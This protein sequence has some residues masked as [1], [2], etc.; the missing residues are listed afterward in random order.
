MLTFDDKRIRV[1]VGHYGSGKTEFSVNYALKLAEQGNKTA[2]ADLDIANP[3]FRSRERQGLLEEQGVRVYSNIFGYDITADLPAITAAIR[4][5]L[6]DPLC[7]I[8]IDA[9]GDH[10]GA[11]ILIQFDR[12]FDQA[13]SDFFCVVN[14]RRPETST[15]A[16]AMNHIFKIEKETG[17]RIT[18]LINN[19]H[20]LKETEAEDVIRGYHLC[21]ELSSRL[22][23]PF[24]YN[25]CV[26]T[27]LEELKQKTIQY[28]D[29]HIF[30]MRLYMRESW[31]DR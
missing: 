19:T 14:G 6:E 3:Y 17:R 30:P 1:V 11:R 31:L 23:V 2:L 8:V 25:C 10:L 29:F 5:P 28:Q 12:Y 21:T 27:L 13:D 7:Q 4:G 20:L 9:G 22:G 18:G 15:L 26:Q 24:K 16:G